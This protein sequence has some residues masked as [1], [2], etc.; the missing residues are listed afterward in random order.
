MEDL[1]DEQ[2]ER[3]LQDLDTSPDLELLDS[4]YDPTLLPLSDG[5]ICGLLSFPPLPAIEEEPSYVSVPALNP[6]NL[7]EDVPDDSTISSDTKT[8]EA[9]ETATAA[10]LLVEGQ[11]VQLDEMRRDLDWNLSESKSH[12]IP[13]IELLTQILSRIFEE[14]QAYQHKSLNPWM[15]QVEGLLRNLAGRS[16]GTPTSPTED[17]LDFGTDRP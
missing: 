11:K 8:N 5:D 9:L 1:T 14:I 13:E 2:F 17:E 10:K 12:F 7:E 6:Q 16:E 3:L 4:F 15:T